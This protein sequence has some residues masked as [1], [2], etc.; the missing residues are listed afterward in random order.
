MQVVWLIRW[1]SAL[2][3]VATVTDFAALRGCHPMT[4]ELGLW[5][6]SQ[7]GFSWFS[8]LPAAYDYDRAWFVNGVTTMKIMFTF[9]YEVRIIECKKPVRNGFSAFRRIRE[10]TKSDYWLRHVC[11][12]V[13]R[14]V[15]AASWNNV[16]PTGRIFTK[17]D[18]WLFLENLSRHFEFHYYLTRITV[19]LHEVLHIIMIISGWILLRMWNVSY[20]IC[21]ENQNA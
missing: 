2:H 14:S 6:M 5:V 18:I 13:R 21:T 9:L 20:K 12:F 1:F 19:T 16:A 3:Q 10:I 15:R 17:I 4:V 8:W 7:A 11:L